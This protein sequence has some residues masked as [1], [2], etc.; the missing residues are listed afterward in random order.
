MIDRT[1]KELTRGITSFGDVVHRFPTGV[2]AIIQVLGRVE[3]S[4]AYI[5]PSTMNV[6]SKTPHK[7]DTNI[8]DTLAPGLHGMSAM[9]IRSETSDARDADIY[10][11]F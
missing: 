1:V 10:R 6:Y 4:L 11:L 3:K 8:S 7:R 5:R 9:D 2:H